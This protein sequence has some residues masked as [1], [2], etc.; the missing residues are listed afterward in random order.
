MTEYNIVE[1]FCLKERLAGVRMDVFHL[2]VLLS[3]L[4]FSQIL[5]DD[6]DL[7]A[8]NC[9]SAYPIREKDN[10][11]TLLKTAPV[12]LREYQYKGEDG[13]KKL[14]E[15]IYHSIA[16]NGQKTSE[17]LTEARKELSNK[18]LVAKLVLYSYIQ[19]VDN[20]ETVVYRSMCIFL[21]LL[22]PATMKRILED[23]KN[24]LLN[25]IENVS[26]V[27]IIFE[28]MSE[29]FILMAEIID[30]DILEDPTEMLTVKYNSLKKGFKL[31]LQDLE[32]CTRV[33]ARNTK[34][35]M[36]IGNTVHWSESDLGKSFINIIKDGREKTEKIFPDAINDWETSELKK[37]IIAIKHILRNKNESGE[38]L[39]SLDD[40]NSA[41]SEW[42]NCHKTTGYKTA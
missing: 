30:D 28:A 1:L 35:L 25:N 5:N 34:G 17:E 15:E 41:V 11:K 29:S 33:D 26:R 27:K 40:L 13:V 37:G 6:F 8:Q 32:F 23:I 22:K 3:S 10:S 31:F 21:F 36:S 42:V 16:N 12:K 7:Y 39:M 20:R 14:E 38:L 18:M 19:H 2:L 4:N 9:I 24:H